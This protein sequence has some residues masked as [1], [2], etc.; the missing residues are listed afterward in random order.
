MIV[1]TVA[2]MMTRMT[3]ETMV[4][5]YLPV[6]TNVASVSVRVLC[7]LHLKHRC[8]KS[9]SMR[10]SRSQLLRWMLHR[11]SLQTEPLAIAVL[12]RRMVVRCLLLIARCFCNDLLLLSL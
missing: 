9:I 11:H 1:V 6:R 10:S 12:N 2:V 5:T 4:R 7:P 8:R 3:R